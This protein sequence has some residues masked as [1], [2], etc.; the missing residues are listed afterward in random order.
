MPPESVLVGALL[1]S[2]VVAVPTLCDFAENET[3]MKNKCFLNEKL[4]EKHFENKPYNLMNYTN[5]DGKLML[6]SSSLADIHA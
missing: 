3:R 2:T 4:G 5:E 1:R 6:K